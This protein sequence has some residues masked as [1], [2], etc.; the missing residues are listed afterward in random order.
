MDATHSG[1]GVAE[2][3]RGGAESTLGTRRLGCPLAL[4]FGDPCFES[5]TWMHGE[6]VTVP[7]SH[8]AT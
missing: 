1:F 5:A 8:A 3:G 4:S 7:C 6:M 2:E